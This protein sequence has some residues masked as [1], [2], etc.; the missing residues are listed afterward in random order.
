MLAERVQR[1]AAKNSLSKFAALVSPKP[2]MTS[3][4]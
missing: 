4:A 1:R 2:P 3:G